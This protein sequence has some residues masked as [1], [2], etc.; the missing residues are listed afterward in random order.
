MDVETGELYSLE[1]MICIKL[2]KDNGDLHMLCFRGRIR[3]SVVCIS[4]NLV[5]VYSGL[6][7]ICNQL[8]Q[9][10]LVAI[11]CTLQFQT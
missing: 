1:L 6:L 10:Y 4:G 5:N 11:Y 8:V 3:G 7:H 9:K 2:E